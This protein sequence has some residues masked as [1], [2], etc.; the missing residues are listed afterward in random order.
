MAP[1]IGALVSPF[2]VVSGG[3]RM[4]PPRGLGRMYAHSALLG[5]GCPGMS[6]DALT[7]TGIRLDDLDAARLIGVAEAAERYAAADL[8]GTLVASI[9][10]RP[11]PAIDP[12]RIPACS[13]TELADPRCPVVPLDPDL[14]IRWVRGLDLATGVPIWVPAV[15][16][17]YRLRDPWPGERFWHRLSTGYAVHTDPVEAVVRGIC[18]VVERDAAAVLWLRRLRL[19]RLARSTAERSETA[20][21][22]LDWNDRHFVDTHLFDATGDLGVP[23]VYCLRIAEHN[24]R[25]RQLVGAASARDLPEAAG[26]ALAEMA[27]GAQVCYFPDAVRE[28]ADFR[29][30][31]DGIRYMA[32][33]ERAEAFDFLVRGP[34]SG[35]SPGDARLP[36]DP[37]EA[38]VRLRNTMQAKDIQVIVVDRTT[39]ELATVG[40][41]AVCVI[42]PD[43]QPLTISPFA[44]YRAHPRLYVALASDRRLPREEEL[45]PWP[46]P[47]G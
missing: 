7:G 5:S 39:R 23:T 27:F 37:R 22:L 8:P 13:A 2:G 43:L 30:V 41:T 17:S 15:M 38:L 35:T 28:P 14:P 36:A 3:R 40:L 44:R 6:R 11:E 26:K 34:D 47:F 9:R 24:R 19:P 16:A 12:A 32:A 10:E 46:Q 4:R 18:E 33:P 1:A 45:N 25:A 42:I 29:A 31:Y 21:Y 20:A